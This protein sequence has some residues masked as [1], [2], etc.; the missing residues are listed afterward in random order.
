MDVNIFTTN[1]IV[2]GS[3]NYCCGVD[4]VV[5]N[6]NL[7]QRLGVDPL[8][9]WSDLVCGAR[10]CADAEHQADKLVQRT[11]FKQVVALFARGK[12]PSGYE[13]PLPFLPQTVIRKKWEDHF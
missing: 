9:I 5:Q 8:R 13:P 4:A 6:A 10:N 3:W 11:V 12:F 2:G 1:Q 7:L